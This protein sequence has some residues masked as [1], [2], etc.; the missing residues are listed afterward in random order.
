MKINEGYEEGSTKI[1][2]DGKS[3]FTLFQT[4]RT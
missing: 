2:N 1:L 3:K 4:T